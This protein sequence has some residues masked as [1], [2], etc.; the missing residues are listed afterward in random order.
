MTKSMLPDCIVNVNGPSLWAI[1]RLEIQGR[2]EPTEMR[3]KQWHRPNVED[4]GAATAKK[5]MITKYKK[6]N[7]FYL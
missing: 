3:P 6:L 4:R 7:Q 2:I 1:Q 5:S